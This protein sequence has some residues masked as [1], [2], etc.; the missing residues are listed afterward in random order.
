[1]NQN[2]ILLKNNDSS[3][4]YWLGIAY[5]NLYKIEKNQEYLTS[6]DKNYNI[7]LNLTPENKEYLYAYAQL[8]FYGFEDYYKA[9]EVLTNLIINLQADVKENYFLLARAYYM[10]GDYKN[11]YQTYNEIYKFQ[12]KLTKQEKEKLEEFI[13]VTRSNLTNE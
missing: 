12:K 1:M 8:L 6:A 7:A 11:A 10:V 4:Y 9:I 5:V 3:A 13:Q 2:N